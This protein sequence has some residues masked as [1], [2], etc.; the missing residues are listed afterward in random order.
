MILNSEEVTNNL[1]QKIEKWKNSLADL[2]KNNPLIQ[3]RTHKRTLEI[4][5]NIDTIYSDIRREKKVLFFD[6]ESPEGGRIKSKEFLT[7]LCCN[8]FQVG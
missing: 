7:I 5:N 2:T 4:T 6:V 8:R 1:R 3:F